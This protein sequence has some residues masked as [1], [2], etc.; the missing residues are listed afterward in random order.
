MDP[1][2]RLEYS[3]GTGHGEPTTWLSEPNLIIG[4]GSTPNA[5]W[6]DFDGDGLIDDAMWDS[7]GDGIADHSVLD[8][9]T[10]DGE[11]FNDENPPRL[12]ADPIGAGTWNQELPAAGSREDSGDAGQQS[13]SG[14][15]TQSGPPHTR[16]V[17]MDN[18]V[19]ADTLAPECVAPETPAPETLAPETHAAVDEVPLTRGREFGL[20]ET[21][22]SET[23]HDGTS[24]I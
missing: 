19:A 20:D 21:P 15:S 4:D 9:I 1:F 23:L 8:L 24:A 6:L 5:V 7:D 22:Q 11:V 18:P 2:G 10:P 3:F 13:E 12:F 14:S 16:S 17:S